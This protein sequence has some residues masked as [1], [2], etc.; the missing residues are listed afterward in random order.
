[1]KEMHNTLQSFNTDYSFIRQVLSVNDIEKVT[2]SGY[3]ILA[4]IFKA[5]IGGGYVVIEQVSRNENG[6]HI[7]TTY[8]PRDPKNQKILDT[9]RTPT[10][11][12]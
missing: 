1:M 10:S 8:D 9:E 11:F 2:T 4:H 7:C 5:G 12:K 6:D 3:P